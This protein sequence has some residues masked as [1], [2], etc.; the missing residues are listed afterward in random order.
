MPWADWICCLWVSLE[1]DEIERY[2]RYVHAGGKPNEWKW[3]Y[4]R[5]DVTGPRGQNIAE[6][7]MSQFEA[8]A[9]EAVSKGRVPQSVF[10]KGSIDEAAERGFV[11]RGAMSSDGKFYD[12]N[13]NEIKLPPGTFFRAR[14]ATD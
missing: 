5:Q 8:A 4:H 6:S 11:Q 10:L 7:I 9:Q 1:L 3:F 12:E 14:R 2:E 13:G